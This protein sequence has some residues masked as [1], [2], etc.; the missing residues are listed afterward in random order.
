MS[1]PLAGLVLLAVVVV[2]LLLGWTTLGTPEAVDAATA[3]ETGFAAERALAHV[4]AIAAEPHPMGT[5]EHARVRDYLVDELAEIGLEPRVQE[6]AVAG[7]GP[8]VG[9]VANV[10]A[11]L[12]GSGRGDEAILLMAHYDSA[13]AS[14]GAADD[15][16]G[17]ATLLE[18]A[19][20]LAAGEPLDHDVVF[21]FSDGE[22][23][24]LLGA[25]AFHAQHPWSQDVAAVLNFEARG[26]RGP[27][28]M[29]ET[30]AD[31][32]WL[33]D[34]FRRGAPHPVAGSYSYEIYRRMPN[35]TD[36]SVFRRAGVPGLNFAFIAGLPAYH[37]ALDTV[38]ALS[39]ESLQHQGS[40]ALGLARELG[41]ADLAASPGG[42][43][44]IYFNL[45]GSA[46]VAYPAGAALVLLGLSLVGLV[47]VVVAG[48]RRGEIDAVGYIMGFCGQFLI[49]VIVTALVVGLGL[50]V[51][52][53]QR[54]FEIWGG[55]S[56]VGL[57][58]GALAL[59]AG[60]VALAGYRLA[61]SLITP[62]HLAVGGA[63]LF[64]LVTALVS[65]AMPGASYLFSWPLLVQL[66][67][68]WLFVRRPELQ[69]DDGRPG[70]GFVSVAALA[71][72]VAG[73]L[74]APALLLVALGLQTMSGGLVAATTLLL[75]ALLAPQV[76][77]ASSPRPRW[78]VPV[79]LLVLATVTVVA[80]RSA[81]AWNATNPRPNTLFYA[82]DADTDD[83]LWVSFQKPD[84]WTTA[85]L[86]EEPAEEPLSQFLGFDRPMFQARAPVA[87]GL[88]G[89][90]LD[91][92]SVEP[93][94]PD[95]TGRLY[96]L[97]LRSGIDGE[98]VRVY[99]ESDAPIVRVEAEGA[100]VAD[101]DLPTG[102]PNGAP[103]RER[104]IYLAPPA[105]GIE[106]AVEL[107][108]AEELELEVIDQRYGLPELGAEGP[109]ER[110]EGL[111]QGY[112]TWDTDSVLVRRSFE[113]EPDMVAQPA[114]PA[115][116][117]AGEEALEEAAGAVGTPA[118]LG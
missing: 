74:W 6:A 10:L 60:G 95:G 20:A 19:R 38:D 98:R 16:S 27:A 7:S 30:G 17:V 39:P 102:R 91:V 108:A 13:P 14:P 11:R 104:F 2:A 1:K 105:D 63:T 23:A 57:I 37:T 69:A 61:R 76:E 28:L 72:L 64:V 75:L 55:W 116:A 49:L 45:V 78:L 40:Y 70:L 29:F 52:E 3:G 81:A 26:N 25:H 66:V 97:R 110:P 8:F 12:E 82:Y 71:L 44:A 93:A 59:A 85:A 68:L 113:V 54:D 86:G 114:E 77:L 106:L 62:I 94:G 96:R 73:A 53:A 51:F 117:G 42:G 36:Y 21:L 33:I 43:D 32:A 9:T 103:S 58:V 48:R 5:A 80:V 88:A 101:N 34:H 50:F 47:L 31:N 107:A 118:D 18:T 84:E 109:G 24:G 41:G 35:D 87:A 65:I 112:M 99:L 89:P 79:A 100:T 111:T 83:A 56:A 115:P 4:R 15:A 46:F 90:R 22:E 67:A 92:V